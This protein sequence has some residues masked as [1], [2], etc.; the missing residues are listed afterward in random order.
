MAELVRAR[1]AKFLVVTLHASEGNRQAYRN[2]LSAAQIDFVD[3]VDP[4]YGTP[5]MVVRGETHPNGAMNTVWADCIEGR[6]R[7]LLAARP[8]A[9][10]V[11][12]PAD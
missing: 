1:G 6:L 2:F 8:A 11:R 7:S 9:A 12:P 10:V 4:R 5:E 3:C